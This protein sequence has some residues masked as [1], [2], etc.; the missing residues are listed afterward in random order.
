MNDI[1]IIFGASGRVDFPDGTCLGVVGEHN[2]ARLALHI[3]P[4]MVDDA[5]QHVVR[6]QLADKVVVTGKITEEPNAAGAYRDENVIY[7]PLTQELT[8]S[9]TVSLRV[10]SVTKI[11]AADAV[12]DSTEPARGLWLHTMDESGEP[13]V[14]PSGSGGSGHTHVNMDSLE[15]IIVTPTMRAMFAN[16]T[17]DL[18]VGSVVI[19]T[20]VDCTQKQ[21]SKIEQE[22]DP[23]VWLTFAETVPYYRQAE[24]YPTTDYAELVTFDQ[25]NFFH[26]FLGLVPVKDDAADPQSASRIGMSFVTNQHERA[27]ILSA[28]CDAFVNDQILADFSYCFRGEI[29]TAILL[30]AY[31]NVNGC[32]QTDAGAVIPGVFNLTQGWNLLLATKDENDQLDEIQI[33]Q[34]DPNQYYSLANFNGD[35]GNASGTLKKA[36]Y[37]AFMF[38]KYTDNRGLWVVDEDGF[39]VCAAQNY[40]DRLSKIE[41]AIQQ[42]HTHSN[43]ASLDK[44][45]EANGVPKYGGKS[46]YEYV[47]DLLSTFTVRG[48]ELYVNTSDGGA[49]INENGELY[50]DTDKSARI[51]NHIL[52]VVV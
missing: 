20:G 25:Q 39:L 51:K 36:L 34:I 15:K 12:L 31:E 32:W 38:D 28:T 23:F 30:Y 22:R 18:E 10:L 40:E 9:P 19:V 46:L 4:S 52:E 13:V 21:F 43:K 14:I 8:V 45:G 35:R 24:T 29:S 50:V 11:G 33:V 16:M 49:E 17:N 7:L 48:D 47:F 42:L 1:R 27:Y 26:V 37:D 3:P 41:T 44:I 2:A 5:T 6:L